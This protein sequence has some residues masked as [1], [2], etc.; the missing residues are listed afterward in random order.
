MSQ[1]ASTQATTDRPTAPVD[2]QPKAPNA[3]G[4]NSSDGDHAAANVPAPKPSNPA[5]R[6]IVIGVVAVVAVFAILWLVRTVSYNLIHASTDDAYVTGNTVNVSPFIAGTLSQLLV[7]EG[8]HV[9][10]GQLIA[11]LDDSQQ[12]AALQQ[13]QAAY[14]AARSQ[15]PEA[16]TTVKFQQQTTDAAV[17]KAQA[18]LRAQQ[19]RTS[20][21]ADLVRLSR[22]TIQSQIDQAQAQVS[23]ARANALQADLSVNERLASQNVAASAVAAAMHGRDALRA[24]IEGAT[25]DVARAEAD[26][27]RYATLLKQEAVTQQQYDAVA[28]QAADVRSNLA[29]LQQQVDQAE[30]Q[31]AQAQANERQAATSVSVARQAAVAAHRQV[32]VAVAGARLAAAGRPQI[33]INQRNLSSSADTEQGSVADIATAKAGQTQV[34]VS[35]QRVLTTRAQVAQAKAAL[36]N[37]K[38]ELSYTYVYAPSDGQVVRKS[39]NPGS[40]VSP[41]QTLVT[42]AQ[43]GAIWI[44]ANFKE[45][46]LG[47]VRVGQPVEIEIDALPGR[48]LEGVVASISDATGASTSLLPPDNATGNFTKV[49][50]R[51]PVRI[52]LAPPKSDAEAEALKLLRQGM[53]VIVGVDIRDKT[54]HPDRV[55]AN[56][57][58][59]PQSFATPPAPS[60]STSPGTIPVPGDTGKDLDSKS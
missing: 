57:E 23:T 21:A 52:A 60:N 17:A 36:D 48:H 46:Q 31:V 22:Q 50:Q 47:E 26:L 3:G 58:G 38:V 27:A 34:E 2:G 55:P 14:D 39:T 16:E 25:A 59:Q 42:L 4:P 49:V 11:R 43:D 54:E 41:G 45:T 10:R 13:A 32:D 30:T 37:A 29:S 8:D 28:A 12:Q 44:T 18:N 6:F 35:K 33:G 40:S 15:L 53:S 19:A 20:G 1:P 24:K 51:I 7:N 5:R 56:Y 9:K